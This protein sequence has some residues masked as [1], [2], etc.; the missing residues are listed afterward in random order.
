MVSLVTQCFLFELHNGISYIGINAAPTVKHQLLK[1]CAFKVNK[2]AA[3]N[4]PI[5]QPIP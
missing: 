1:I 4:L 5:G 3:C 2:K